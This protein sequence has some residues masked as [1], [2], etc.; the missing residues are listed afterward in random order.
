MDFKTRLQNY[1]NTDEFWKNLIDD[2]NGMTE[3]NR[4]KAQM[5]LLSFIIPKVKSED[6]ESLRS[7][8]NIEIQ[9]IEDTKG[10]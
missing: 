6:G 5:E 9:Y 4:F 1:V 2:V 3:S 8:P 10:E 7:P